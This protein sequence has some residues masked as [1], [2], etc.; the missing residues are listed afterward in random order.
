MPNPVVHFE[1]VTKDP[2]ALA[3]F[4]RSAFAWDLDATHP[5]TGANGVP[6]Y[7]FARPLGQDVAAPCAINGGIGGSPDGYDGHVTFYIAVDDVGAALDDV[8]KLGGARMMGPAQVPDGPV[9]GL[10]KDPQ[11]HVVGLVKPEM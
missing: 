11:G 10:F 3:S 7:I 1:I 6:K 2:D 4:Y 9:I 5:G 8:E